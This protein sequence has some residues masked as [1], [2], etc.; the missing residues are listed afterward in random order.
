MSHGVPLRYSF[1]NL[2]RRPGRTAL[3]LVG[4]SLIVALIVFLVAFGRSFGLALRLPGDPQNL[5]VLSKKAQTFE[6]QTASTLR[7][8]FAQL[9][10]RLARNSR[11]LLDFAGVMSLGATFLDAF[12]LFNRNLQ[13]KGSRMALCCLDPAVRKLFFATRSP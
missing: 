13:T 10:D 9:A 4:L 7:E 11:V 8:D 2:R 5:I 6:E 1:R 12:V 3:T